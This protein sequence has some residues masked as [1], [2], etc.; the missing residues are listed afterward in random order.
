MSSEAE[1]MRRDF[2]SSYYYRSLHGFKGGEKSNYLE[3]LI[4]MEVLGELLTKEKLEFIQYQISG[5]P[6]PLLIVDAETVCST[7]YQTTF[8]HSSGKFY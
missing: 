8:D 4:K 3:A 5:S 7:H 1:P 2:R 6:E